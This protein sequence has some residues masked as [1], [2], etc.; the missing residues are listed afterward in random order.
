MR[1]FP[2]QLQKVCI[3]IKETFNISIGKKA[4]Q[5]FIKKCSD[6]SW[7]RIRKTPKGEPDPEVYKEKK[8]ELE[9][10]EDQAKADKLDLCYVDESGF[11]L[12]SNVPYAWQEKGNTLEIKTSSSRRLNVF[13][14]LNI[15]SEKGLTAFTFEGSIT[16]EVVIACIDEFCKAVTRKSMLIIDNASIHTSQAFEDK[17]PEWG[18]KNVFIFRLPTYSPQLNLI[19][20]LWRFMKYEWIKLEAYECWQSLVNYVEKVIR[21]YGQDY[22]INFKK[23]S[24]FTEKKA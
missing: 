19:E 16:S 14:F 10:L 5:K 11:S 6:Y 3:L 9:R 21:N 23:S 1:K 18:K 8:E 17:I 20:I 13:G 4:L 22:K 7:R 2:K 15:N 12:T 24:L